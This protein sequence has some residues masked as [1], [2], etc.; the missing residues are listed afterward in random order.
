M[1]CVAHVYKLQ[2]IEGALTDP[3]HRA[4]ACSKRF[5]DLAVLRVLSGAFEAIAD[6]AFMLITSSFSAYLSA[7]VD[8]EVMNLSQQC[9]TLG[10]SNLNVSQLGCTPSSPANTPY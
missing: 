3:L 9:G 2:I 7:Q 5:V 6:P 10:K 4:Q 8:Y 1:G